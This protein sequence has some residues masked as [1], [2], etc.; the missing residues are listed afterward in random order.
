MPE[1][2][3]ALT[4]LG[5]KSGKYNGTLNFGG[6]VKS[7]H[8]PSHFYYTTAFCPVNLNQHCSFATQFSRRL[9]KSVSKNLDKVLLFQKKVSEAI[10]NGKRSYFITLYNFIPLLQKGG[11]S[12]LGINF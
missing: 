9:I 2:V 11:D 6:G 1:K 5:V 3:G 4:P 7:G 12:L 8:F 10:T